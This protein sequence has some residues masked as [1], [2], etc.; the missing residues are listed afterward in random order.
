MGL[1]H[2][3]HHWE[4]ADVFHA[5]VWLSDRDS[6]PVSCSRQNVPEQSRGGIDAG[7]MTK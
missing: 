6:V 7:Q 2:L 5:L 1:E 4:F 3:I